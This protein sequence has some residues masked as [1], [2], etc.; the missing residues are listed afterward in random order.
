M[1][2][3]TIATQDVDVMV[4]VPPSG[5]VVVNVSATGLVVATW[6]VVIVLSILAEVEV[7]SAGEEEEDFEEA[8]ES[9]FDDA[10][11]GFEGEVVVKKEV[12]S[13]FG[14]VLEE[15]TGVSLKEEDSERISCLVED[16]P[17]GVDS[18]LLV[19][20]GELAGVELGGVGV[21]GAWV[22]V[23]GEVVGGSGVLVDDGV[24]GGLVVD[25]GVVVGG[26]CFDVVEGTGVVDVGFSEVALD[27]PCSVD[28]ATVP[29][30]VAL[31]GE[32]SARFPRKARAAF[33]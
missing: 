7:S 18:G 12:V 13:S 26:C 25:D 19:V 5:N 28:A 6:P 21:E 11:G 3:G 4:R 31:V 27:P 16:V 22:V 24:D 17:E 10:G 33:M 1:S 15:D 20:V 23:D 8:L 2:V 14:N 29:A 9:L 32:A 30:D